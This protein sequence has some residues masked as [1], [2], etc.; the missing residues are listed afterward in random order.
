MCIADQPGTEGQGLEQD[1][2]SDGA[3]EEG[4]PAVA[5]NSCVDGR[6]RATY[7]DT[8]LTPSCCLQLRQKKLSSMTK[9]NG[10]KS[11]IVFR[12]ERWSVSP[13]ALLLHHS[14]A[15]H[16]CW[17]DDSRQRQAATARLDCRGKMTF[18]DSKDIETHIKAA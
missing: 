16:A 3:Q 14:S 5:K 10:A 11:L 8:E 15:A 4:G 13:F 6:I 12:G 17:A 9:V 18:L 2:I 1:P 7:H